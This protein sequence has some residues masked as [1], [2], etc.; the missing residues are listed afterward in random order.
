MNKKPIK[1]IFG[2]IEEITFRKSP[3][4]SFSDEDW[5]K[6]NSF[7]V[8]RFLSQNQNYIESV[9]FVQKQNPQDHKKI[10]AIYKEL[11]PKA[12]VWTKYVKNQKLRDYKSIPSFLSKYFECSIAE[13]TD[14][15]ELL[16]REEIT[17]ILSKMGEDEK[18]IKKAMKEAKL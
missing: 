15:V 11:I 14:Y 2:W 1:N 12:R 5:G 6:W 8:H 18:S 7:M 3:I 4:E 16:P 10:Y 13:A 17:T 9:N